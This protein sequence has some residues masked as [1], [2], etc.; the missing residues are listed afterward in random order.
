MWA[1]TSPPMSSST[2]NVVFGR[3]VLTRPSTSIASS[4]TFCMPTSA[5]GGERKRPREG[6]PTCG[7]AGILP[8]LRADRE[9]TGRHLHR[10]VPD[11]VRRPAVRR[12]RR[13]G[14][15]GRAD[16]FITPRDDRVQ[17]PDRARHVRRGRLP[18]D[19]F[20]LPPDRG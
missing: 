7:H 10:P 9:W 1:I 18:P 14:T 15:A 5:C 3:A 16:P 12:P 11:L 8:Q 6:T 19:R 2:R 17:L 4:L 13:L 20:H